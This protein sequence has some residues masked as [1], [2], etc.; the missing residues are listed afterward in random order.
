MFV[1]WTLVHESIANVCCRKK[2]SLLKVHLIRLKKLLTK[3]E[4]EGSIIS[5]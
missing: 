1:F 2:Q 5:D 3:R 4:V